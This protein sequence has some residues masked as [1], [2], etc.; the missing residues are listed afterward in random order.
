[1]LA[2]CYDT[3]LSCL[4]YSVEDTLTIP[5]KQTTHTILE[6]SQ[7]NCESAKD[8]LSARD[9][10]RLSLRRE[11][12]AGSASKETQCGRSH[13]GRA[14]AWVVLPSAWYTG[15]RRSVSPQRKRASAML[16]HK[17][18][19]HKLHATGTHVFRLAE[20]R[21]RSGEVGEVQEW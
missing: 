7:L 19:P 12:A 18:R 14:L 17:A 13:L 8:T 20:E 21:S 6:L 9:T 15:N 5:D 1:M 3:L 10:L 4:L 16:S 11:V 2:G